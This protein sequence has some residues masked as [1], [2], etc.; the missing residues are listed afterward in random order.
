MNEEEKE[1]IERTQ[2]DS[3]FREREL[4][5]INRK[6]TSRNRK[7]KNKARKSKNRISTK[8]YNYKQ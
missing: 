8:Y 7:I 5:R 1:I 6:T 2:Q 3:T 4:L